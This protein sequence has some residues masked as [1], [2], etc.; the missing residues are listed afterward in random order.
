M[1]ARTTNQ[2]GPRI[3]AALIFLALCGTV[4]APQ[5]QATNCTAAAL[6]ALGIANVTIAS[7]TD[8]PAAAPNP[9]YCDVK[10]SL[11]TNGEGAGPGSARFE[12]MLPA[13]WNGKFVFHGVG[14][15]AG[16]LTSSANP[17]DRALFLARGYAT[18]ITDT[19]HVSTDL[20][21][22]YTSP[23]QP[24]TARIVDYFYRA[25]HQVT[26]AAKQIVKAYYSSAAIS[27]SYF[28]G[29]S[30]GGKMGLIEAMRYPD[31]YD[32]VIAGAPWLDP[33]GTSLWSLKNI[34][35]LLS[36][37]IPPSLFAAIDA[38]IKKQCDRN[39][40]LADALIQNPAKCSFNPGTLV[41]AILTR[42]QADALK[43]IINP[44][45]DEKGGLVYPGSSVSN[46]GQFPLGTTGPV[47]ELEMQAANPQAP[48]PWGDAAP[49]A[50]WNL[51]IGIILNLGFYDSGVD[52]NNAVETNGMVKSATLKL[53][54]DHL[55]PDIPDDPARLAPFFD[56]GGKLLIYHGYNDLIISPYRSVWFYEDLAA[57]TGGY[58]KLQAHARLFMAP[59]MLHCSGG[60]G[61]NAFETLSAMEK[62]VES[63]VAPDAIVASHATNGATDRTMPLCKFPEQAHYKAKGEVNDAANWTCPANDRSLLEVGP[64]GIQS[65]VG[66]SN[67][68]VQAKLAVTNTN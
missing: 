32:G 40:G 39:D 65:G 7:A 29:C 50:N 18:A 12:V 55:G 13:N 14:G 8:V 22:E 45:R 3:L 25:V 36:D 41:P 49:P 67:H 52:L 6:S 57:K 2:F 9:R 64:N 16:T 5:A 46:L 48:Q 27:R 66:S 34:K 53:L 54:Y 33:L 62:W 44:V 61:P 24:N 47:N 38:E 58:D 21:W 42:R 31:D 10:G 1:N 43:S 20:T 11:A 23:G 68:A 51:G 26:L 17:V 35:A 4:A 28:D 60:P 59:G 63:G 19:G 15:L 37:Y 56:K 30:N